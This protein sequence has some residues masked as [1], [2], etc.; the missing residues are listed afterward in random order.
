MTLYKKSFLFF[1]LEVK[2]PGYQVI[3]LSLFGVILERYLCDDDK[4]LILVVSY[5]CQSVFLVSFIGVNLL[6]YKPLLRGLFSEGV[7][8]LKEYGE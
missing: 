3:L 2:L 6:L 1:L 7:T 8:G 5:V 4:Q